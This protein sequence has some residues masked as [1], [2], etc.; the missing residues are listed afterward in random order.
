MER[1][2]SATKTVVV[3]TYE[4]LHKEM[5]RRA[6][7]SRGGH[8]VCLS[9]TVKGLWGHSQ[10]IWEATPDST[11]GEIF[12]VFIQH[13]FIKSGLLTVLGDLLRRRP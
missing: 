3:T 11:E 4:Q 12:D 8:G 7:F 6:A 5:E 10:L 9:G 13:L 1:Q 2:V